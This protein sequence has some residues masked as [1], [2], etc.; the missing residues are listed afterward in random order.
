[1]S[2]NITLRLD[3]KT[4]QRIKHLAVDRHTSVSAWVG[5]LVTRAAEELDGFVPER[6][7]AL[8]DLAHPVAIAD[9]TPLGREQ[10]HER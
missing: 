4:I 3:A 2:T 1:M 5:E 6:K 8:H 7:R 10:T 9:A